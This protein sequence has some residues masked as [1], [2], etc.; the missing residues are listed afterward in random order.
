MGERYHAPLRRI[1]NKIRYGVPGVDF[2]LG[3][4]LAIMAM[5]DTMGPNGLIPSYLVF[6]VLPRYPCLNSDLPDPEARMNIIKL[7]KAE[8]STIVSE[9]RVKGALTYK[10]LCCCDYRACTWILGKIIP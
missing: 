2:K 8:M 5:S 7:A 1:F 4:R 9:I 3:L 10:N 6:G